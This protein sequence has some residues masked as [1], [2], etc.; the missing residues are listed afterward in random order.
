MDALVSIK[1][2]PEV[3]M[4]TEEM[5]TAAAEQEPKGDRNYSSD[6][7]MDDF[8]KQDD[9]DDDQIHTGNVSESTEA[10]PQIQIKQEFK[11]IKLS[12]NCKSC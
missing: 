11:N 8:H 4:E 12:S 1:C 6:A 9:G 7:N 2:D 10:T 3:H 5:P